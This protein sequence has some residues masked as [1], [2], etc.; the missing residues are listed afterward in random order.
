MLDRD[1]ARL[2]ELLQHFSGLLAPHCDQV[3]GPLHLFV[4][5]RGYSMACACG[6]PDV[7]PALC[8]PGGPGSPSGDQGDTDPAAS[9]IPANPPSPAAAAVEPSGPL[10]GP[11]PDDRRVQA[12]P[13]ETDPLPGPPG[14]RHQHEY[15][16]SSAVPSAVTGPLPGPPGA[17][18]PR[19]CSTSPAVLSPSH[20]TCANKVPTG[21]CVPAV[22]PRGRSGNDSA[23]QMASMVL[24]W[25]LSCA[26]RPVWPLV[27]T[28]CALVSFFPDPQEASGMT[29]PMVAA[30]I[31]MVLFALRATEAWPIVNPNPG[32]MQNPLGRCPLA[33]A[34]L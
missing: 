8:E 4:D 17:L 33:L 9:P 31:G 14:A 12:Q 29:W 23:E 30:C 27:A 2:V 25:P 7:P 13:A 5:P 11:F 6:T 26:L 1:E 3:L 21:N 28:C 34:V 20:P 15:S 32:R 24:A 10:T 22:L 18:H 19:E 16:A